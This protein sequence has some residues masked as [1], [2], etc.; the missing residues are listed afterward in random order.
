MNSEEKYK[1]KEGHR[2]IVYI[3]GFPVWLIKS[4]DLPKELR[5]KNGK[6]VSN[7]LHT[8]TL[9]DPIEPSGTKIVIDHLLNG[10]TKNIKIFMLDTMGEIIEQWIFVEATI[11]SVDFDTLDWAKD[12]AT[13]IK[14]K[15]M[16]KEAK[17]EIKQ[18][19]N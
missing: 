19:E 4:I 11:D 15:F 3:D 9:Y 16:F 7:Q 12:D 8:M 10:E 6:L 18:K 13:N 5:V 17:F 1:P 14:I 2:F